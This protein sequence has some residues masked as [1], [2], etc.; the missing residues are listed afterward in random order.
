VGYPSDAQWLGHGT[1]LLADYSSPGHVLI[2]NRR[3]KVLWRYGPSSGPGALD[4]PSLA[5][6]LPGG[7]IAVNDDYRHRVVL[8]S[9]K[10]HRIVWQYG[11][12]D[13]P[14]TAPGS[15]DTPDG[16]DFLPFGMA[17]RHPQ[18]RTLVLHHSR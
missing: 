13:R 18:L 12:T 7:L 15:L 10:R 9:R 5:L 11:H 3:G 2:M 8:I 6:M 1:F 17:M 16:M 14:G 4:H